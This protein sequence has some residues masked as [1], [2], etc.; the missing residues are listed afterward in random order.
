[1][2]RFTGILLAALL[3]LAPLSASALEALT[4]SA[5]GDVTGQ[6]GVAI[7]LDD[8]VILIEGVQDTIYTD[9]DTGLGI[10]IDQFDQ[11]NKLILLDAIVDDSTGYSVADINTMF[12]GVQGWTNDVAGIVA[13]ADDLAAEAA[14][15]KF[16]SVPQ[17][18]T[19]DIQKCKNLSRG[20]SFK[21]GLAGSP[22][23][24]GGVVIGLPTVTIDIFAT[25][26]TKIVSLTHVS[27]W[28]NGDTALEAALDNDVE[29]NVVALQ[30]APRNP[31]N[32]SG[33]GYVQGTAALDNSSTYIAVTK[34]GHAKYAILGGSLEI[35]PH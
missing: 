11:M 18:L 1:M 35:A 7:G 8:V 19:I 12:A 33:A 27:E 4:D 15:N 29:E 32:G 2:K 31:G 16:Q 23:Y 9:T 14:G 30:A 22:V 13:T 21:A 3:V 6:A 28:S 5:M 34:Q 20:E 10:K 25:Q 17:A 24:V 26:D